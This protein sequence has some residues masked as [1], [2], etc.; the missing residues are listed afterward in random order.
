MFRFIKS[1]KRFALCGLLAGILA[2][3]PGA[4]GQEWRTLSGESRNSREAF[5]KIADLMPSYSVSALAAAVI[6][7]GKIV[8]ICHSGQFDRPRGV[9]VDEKTVFRAASLSKPVFAY[10]TLR[11]ADEGRIG[12]DRPLEQILGKP[13]ESFPDYRDLS[14]DA[15]QKRLTPRLLLSHQGG[16]PNW[17][18]MTQNRLIFLADPGQRFGYSGEGYYLMQFV[19]ETL[20][21]VPLDRL[22]RKYVFL[23]LGLEE[24]SYL[25]EPRFDGRFAVDLATGL[26]PLIERTRTK[27]N[28]AGSLI[29]RAED[30]AR[31]LQA[32]MNGENLKPETAKAMRTPQTVITGPI[33]GPSRPEA[34]AST[35]PA[36][37]SWALGWGRLPSPAGEAFFHIGQEDGCENY[38]VFF[39]E[40]RTGL[41]LLTVCGE[42]I[43]I[44]SEVSRYLIGD[45][46]SPFSW[47]GY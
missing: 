21:G 20:T 27:A 7:D 38:A 42:K 39:P 2:G 31:F 44:A 10:L 43:G 46:Y 9:R 1:F 22:A 16:L 33:I 5:Q 6:Q 18:R 19:L 41:V 30:Y 23:P 4:F 36:G 24:T 17:R 13:L 12:L 26:R 15:R 3:A 28:A 11:L 45:L 40:K 34:A 25:W 29:T 14:A 32:A 35:P 47:M 8:F 37:L